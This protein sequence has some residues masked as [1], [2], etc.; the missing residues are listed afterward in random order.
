MTDKSA[1]QG[2]VGNTWAAQWAR[3]DRSFAGLT[4]KLLARARSQPIRRAVDIGCGAGELSM[5]LARSHPDGEVIG[6]DVSADLIEAARE[7]AAHLPNVSFEL[8]DAAQWAKTG[9][10]PDLLVSRHGVM[11]FDQPVSAFANLRRECSEAARMV[12]SCFR[13][14]S[15]NPWASETVALLP[16]GAASPS[17]PAAP[18]PFA[19]ADAH[20]V[21]GILREAGWRE[22]DFE[23]VD[24][25]FVVGAGDDPVEDAMEY[26][27]VIGPVAR[28]AAQLPEGEKAL[29]R[30]RLRR[31]LCRHASGSLVALQ[32]GAWIVTATT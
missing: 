27:A 31:H 6:V 18:G 5:A 10:Q 21:E 23:A 19:F 29:F 11:F 17:H 13:S 4:D 25:A 14:P 15:D 7:R 22:I 1:W 3:T 2:Q 20:Y 28:A 12:F 16:S 24:F 26:F 9:W 8:A 32:A 30:E